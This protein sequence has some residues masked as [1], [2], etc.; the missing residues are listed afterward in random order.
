MVL[1]CSAGGYPEDLP[2][3]RIQ[4]GMACGDRVTSESGCKSCS[5]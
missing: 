3:A 2:I 4:A 1:E 5:P